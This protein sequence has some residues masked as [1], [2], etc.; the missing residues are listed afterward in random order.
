[1]IDGICK[2][3]NKHPSEDEG[4]RVYYAPGERIAGYNGDLCAR[5]KPGFL[6]LDIDDFDHRT[7]EPDEPIKGKP[8]SE[9]VLA[10]LDSKG[11][12]YNLMITEHGKHFYFRVP[13]NYP[14]ETNKINWYS[15]LGIKAEVKLGGGQSKE[16]IPFKVGGVLRFHPCPACQWRR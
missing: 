4:S 6:K 2:A 11:I 10:W 12:R 7:N 9:A 3:H 14:Y 16:H 8:R 1:M 15:A 13:Q 5:L